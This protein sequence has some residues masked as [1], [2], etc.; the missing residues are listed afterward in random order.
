MYLKYHG[1]PLHH[2][3]AEVIC[4][5]ARR[6]PHSLSTVTVS[7]HVAKHERHLIPNVGSVWA[8]FSLIRVQNLNHV[9]YSFGCY[10]HS[11]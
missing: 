1:S 9:V 8:H 10:V 7:E 2:K 11:K 4:W 3:A 6:A 5:P